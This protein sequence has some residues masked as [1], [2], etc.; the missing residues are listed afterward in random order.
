[1]V[2]NSEVPKPPEVII[3]NFGNTLRKGILKEYL[4][5][6]MNCRR[7]GLFCASLRDS[8]SA[9][10][11]I[12]FENLRNLYETMKEIG[13]LVLEKKISQFAIKQD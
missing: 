1:M 9:P 2:K 12:R 7:T 11:N 10:L 8:M 6:D 3:K 5:K 4:D 13:E